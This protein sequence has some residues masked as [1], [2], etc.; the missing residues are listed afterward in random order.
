MATTKEDA[1]TKRRQA[2]DGF[3]PEERKAQLVDALLAERAGYVQ[4]KLPERV[5]LV[6]EQIKANGGKVPTSRGSQA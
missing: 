2:E 3:T 6:D 4:R 5:A 1:A